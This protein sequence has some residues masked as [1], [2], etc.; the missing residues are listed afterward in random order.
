MGYAKRHEVEEYLQKLPGEHCWKCKFFDPHE[1][2]TVEEIR[3]FENQ[4]L[5]LRGDCR[6][7]PPLIDFTDESLQG[8]WPS[9][10]G[11]DYCGSFSECDR[12]VDDLTFYGR[13]GSETEGE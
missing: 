8:V 13:G 5:D 10:S 2:V 12:S 3:G 11:A 9:V 6:A 7:N 1:E 4:Y